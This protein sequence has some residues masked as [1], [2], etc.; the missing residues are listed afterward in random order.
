MFWYLF[1]LD[2]RLGCQE[3]WLQ[4]TFEVKLSISLCSC[5]LPKFRDEIVQISHFFSKRTAVKQNRPWIWNTWKQV[6]FSPVHK[7]KLFKKVEKICVFL[8]LRLIKK[9]SI[10]D[11]ALYFKT[12]QRWDFEQINA[13]TYSSRNLIISI[14]SRVMSSSFVSFEKK[15][16]LYHVYT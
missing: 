5:F 9:V 6:M 16:I 8:L 2:F 10:K 3:V 13:K 4:S 15:I 14:G 7:F 12:I 11:S 1:V